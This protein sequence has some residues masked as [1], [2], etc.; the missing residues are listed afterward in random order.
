[1]HSKYITGKKGV[2][3]IGITSKLYFKLDKKTPRVRKVRF[4]LKL[5]I[6]L[7][8]IQL[9]LKIFSCISVK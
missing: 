6:I 9:H 4:I 7:L 5:K 8:A 1:M 2:Y 3:D